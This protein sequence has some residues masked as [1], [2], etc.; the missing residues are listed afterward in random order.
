MFKRVSKKGLLCL[1]YYGKHAQRCI[2]LKPCNAQVL[3]SV[4]I[5]MQVNVSSP[6]AKTTESI[7][8]CMGFI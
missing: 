2:V 3:K 6:F 4:S 5:F 1:Q 8:H 7:F